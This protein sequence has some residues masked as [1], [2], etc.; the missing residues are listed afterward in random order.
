MKI[1]HTIVMSVFCKE[2][3][4]EELEKA[5]HT[6]M[7]VDFQEQKI[8]FQKT[9]A[10]GVFETSITVITMTLQKEKHIKLF[11][12]HL[13]SQLTSEQKELLVRQ[14]DTRVDE[15]LNFYL[16]L[17]KEKLLHNEYWITDSG[18]CFHIKMNLAAYPKK[19]EK[20]LEIIKEIFK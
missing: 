1:I 19:K 3:Q 12:E 4:I 8:T 18:D 7:P 17:D 20:A 6:F 10:K 15:E 14:F 2:E 11:V 16:R 13:V 9:M 5:F